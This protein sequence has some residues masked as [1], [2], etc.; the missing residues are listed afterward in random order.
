[1][2]KQLNYSPVLAG[3]AENHLVDWPLGQIVSMIN[4]LR[5]MALKK[6]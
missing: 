4:A 5:L 3:A 1:V 6:E 2:L